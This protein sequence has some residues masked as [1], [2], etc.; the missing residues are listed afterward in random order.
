MRTAFVAAFAFIILNV[1]AALAQDAFEIRVSIAPFAS[2]L[3][4]LQ[5]APMTSFT[6][7]VPCVAPGSDPTSSKVDVKVDQFPAWATATVSPTEFPLDPMTCRAGRI[8]F[9]GTLTVAANDQAPA[10]TPTPLTIAATLA[11]ANPPIRGE[12]TVA[13]TAGYFSVLDI[14][15]AETIKTTA[16]DTDVEFPLTLTNLGNGKTRVTFEIVE[17]GNTLTGQ[18]PSPIELQSKQQGGTQTSAT[19]LLQLHTRAAKGYANEVSVANYR[20][21]SALAED[22]TMKGDEAMV[23]VLVTTKGLGTPG[24][25]LALLTL[26]AAAA[27]TL[28][29]R[30]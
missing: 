12:G 8:T 24:P 4:P 18:A 6:L 15:L 27:V 19:V 13:V 17:I 7:D 14:Q 26:A 3:A 28:R 22:P 20:I 10:F 21:T 23:S 2:P 30:A 29:R 11:N 9:E 1:P 25:G 5:E 16:P